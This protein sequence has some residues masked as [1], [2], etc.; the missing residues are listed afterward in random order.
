MT[1]EQ[2]A[3]ELKASPTGIHHKL[4][5]LTGC[6]LSQSESHSILARLVLLDQDYA[7]AVSYVQ[8]SYNNKRKAI[9]VRALSCI[10]F[11]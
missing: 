3:A 7:R 8:N 11:I 4:L 2:I 5:S 1:T 6:R 9:D 10:Y